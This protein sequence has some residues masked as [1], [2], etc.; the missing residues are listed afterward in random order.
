MWKQTPVEK[1]E[2]RTKALKALTSCLLVLLLIGVFAAV[3]QA[4]VL[5]GSL[6]GN[7]T[8]ASGAAVPGAKVEALNVN[9]G[10]TRDTT[11]DQSG[12]YRLT[13]L[14]PGTYKV[15]VTAPKFAGNVTENVR[16]VVNN[17]TR[18]DAALK[19]ASQQ[20]EV[21]VTTEAPLLQTDK[22]D[23]HTDLS[24]QQI[25]SLPTMSSQG[26]NFQ[27]LLRIIPGV[28]LTAET[29]SISGNPQRA[30][31]ANVNGQ[32]NQSVN[33]RIDGA[34]NL[35]P[36][37]PANV[38]Y[39]PPADAIE[40]V[41]VSTNSFDAEQGMAGGAAVN[42]QIKS[43]TNEYHGSGHWFHTDQNFAARNYFNTDPVRFPK[44]NRNNQNQFGGTFGGPVVKNKLF[45][46]TDWE[47]TTQRNLAGPANRIL[48]IAQMVQGDFRGLGVNIYD[49]RTGDATG[50]NRQ[51]I[52]CNG[53]QNVIC[54]AD[55]D[56]AAAKMI[57][58]MGPNYANIFSNSI[59][60]NNFTAS[61]TAK[62]NRDNFDAKV[63][64]VP[65][66]KSTLF[67][68][69]SFSKI[70]VFDPPIFGDAGGDAANGGQLG[71]STGLIQSVG[72]GGTYTFTPTVLFDW[73]AGFT[74]QRLGAGFD[75]TT[76]RG[77]SELGIPGTN[78]VGFPGDPTLYNGLPAFTFNASSGSNL[79]SMGNTNTGNPFT[80][81]D[82]QYVWGTNLSWIRGKHSFRGGVEYNHAQINHFQPQ[83]GTFQTPRG[84]F[85]FNGTATSLLTVDPA[86]AT[87]RIV[88]GGT[89]ANTW[90]DFL[91]GLPSATGKAGALFNPT[92]LRWSQ[93]AW[94][95]RDQWQVFP[96]LT[97]TLGVR[98][99]YYPF[100]YSD[101]DKGLRWFN[102]DDG[103]V[104]IGGYGN[105]P[106]NDGID[107]GNGQ[108]LPRIGLAYRVTDKTVIRAGYG[109]SADPNNWRYFRNAYPAALLANN[110]QPSSTVLQPI[111]SLSCTAFGHTAAGG[112]VGNCNV[113]G[114]YNIDTG[115]K[116][117][118]LPNIS[119]GVIPL[120]TNAG[121]TTIP[122]PFRRGYINSFNFMIQQEFKGFVL[123][124]GYV[125]A[126]AIRPLVNMN[127]NASPIGTGQA[128]G[129]INARLRAKGV[130][131][132]PNASC[133]YG[134][135]G[136]LVPFKNNYYDSLQTKLTR[137]F[138][139]GS[140][141]GF[142]WTWSKAIDYQGNEELSGLRN[143]YPDYWESNRAPADFDRTH[144]FKV[145]GVL[146]SPF[147]KGQQFMQEGWGGKVLGGW[148]LNPVVTYLTGTPFSVFANGNTLNAQG[149]QQYA[150][151]VGTYQTT[152]GK[153]VRAGQSCPAGMLSCSYFDPSAFA[154]PANGRF[155]NTRRNQFRGPG[156]FELDLAL[157]REFRLTERFNLQLRAEAFSLTNTPHFAN[158][159]STCPN[160]TAG[161]ACASGTFGQITGTAS[162]GGFFGP[163]PG[164]RTI[165][166]AG[167]L[168]F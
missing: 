10:I 58:L 112:G 100:G 158:P 147:G 142:V 1:F 163:D 49:P 114:V 138:T 80:F 116:N 30:I 145:Y 20:S 134:N 78:G 128:G 26:R 155:G 118:A 40:T 2:G 6:T 71:D 135:I 94:Y 41:N 162:P 27:S 37:L 35:Y 67:G 47:R 39:V 18:V 104:Y 24:A 109:M 164:A 121:T 136:G 57:G 76:D 127:L 17:I 119:T 123:E 129:M 132:S 149:A 31:N 38:A 74:R 66:D 85:Q 22:A 133:N 152:D 137:R 12:I 72:L 126:R 98:W 146:L 96:N 143:P 5:Y 156:Y 77:V 153:P 15:T 79:A 63:N 46:F 28:G 3:G 122:N 93:W 60:A 124:T 81:R 9:T 90:A 151:L 92:S 70:L 161:G 75:L 87:K 84:T 4:Q 166:L 159:N 8:D 107:V 82:N 25:T 32:S 55:F 52:S 95:L 99:E 62:F 69:Y 148:Q 103:N 101:N 48:P 23:V 106:K 45:F 11:T 131:C 7:V 91:L 88:V 19:V 105:V 73:N 97:L 150:D 68:R 43:G 83:G 160:A 34:Q 113:L 111:A 89:P 29:N 110:T 154:A 130:T 120:P 157:V 56:Q 21:T 44:K 140:T 86:D 117:I 167:K 165:W 168:T 50:L 13:S 64:Y 141:A 33:T 125:G 144:N 139:G 14:Q 108:F 61:G 16:V 102:Q 54:P 42:V 53:V 51:I 36:W 65:S 115:L 59:S